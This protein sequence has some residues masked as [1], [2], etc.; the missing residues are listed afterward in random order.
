MYILTASLDSPLL[1]YTV[2]IFKVDTV[3]HQ[4]EK[5]VNAKSIVV[6]GASTGLG[7]GIVDVLVRKGLPPQRIGRS[8]PQGPGRPKPKVCYTVLQQKFKN[9]TLPM[10]LPKRL[11]ECLIGKQLGLLPQSFSR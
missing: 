4:S 5:S 3:Y 9:W 1:R 8:S 7:W 10:D 2:Y 11:L 6:T